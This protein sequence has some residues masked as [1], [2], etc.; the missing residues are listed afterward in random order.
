MKQYIVIGCGRFG[1]S[2]ARTLYGLGYDV[3]AIDKNEDKIQALSNSVTHAIQ[4]DG[5]D[6]SS[7]KSIG[8]RNFD[9]AIITIGTDIQASI[10]ATLLT[11]ELGVQ[12]VI[13]KAHNE[14]HSKILY[15]IGAD[16]V[17][18]PERDMGIR[19]AHNLTSSNILDF[20]ELAPNYSIIEITALKEWEGKSLIEINMRKKYG[21]NVMAIKQGS[22]INIS[23]KASEEISNG[24]ILIMVGHNDDL[25]KIEKRA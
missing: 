1:S 6:E 24:D 9:V 21:V 16:R 10:L 19:V 11:K 12:Y 7:L 18:L 5:V 23:P 15:K 2:I 3:L 8:I 25:L 14:L 17:V 13:A 20:I 4:M 22:Q